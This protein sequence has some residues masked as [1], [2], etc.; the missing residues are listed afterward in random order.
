DHVDTPARVVEWRPVPADD[1][2]VDETEQWLGTP[3]VERRFDAARRAGDLRQVPILEKCVHLPADRVDKPVAELVSAPRT[4]RV[5]DLREAEQIDPR[6]GVHFDT[7]R[8]ELPEAVAATGAATAAR[9]DIELLGAARSGGVPVAAQDA[10]S[11]ERRDDE[12]GAS[13]A[14]DDRRRGANGIGVRGGG[15]DQ[16]NAAVA[17]S[18][19]PRLVAPVRKTLSCSS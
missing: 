16:R 18:A 10:V 6:L 3:F 15:V 11:R 1:G 7:A 9:C 5:L 12:A 8:H 17:H 4:A 13:K 14:R 2:E 19:A